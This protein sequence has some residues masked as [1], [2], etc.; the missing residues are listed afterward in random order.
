MH[1]NLIL[2]VLYSSALLMKLLTVVESQNCYCEAKAS[3]LLNALLHLHP[4]TIITKVFHFVTA[5][6][7]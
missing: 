5:V 2:K 1:T 3:L 6:G 7:H 4:L